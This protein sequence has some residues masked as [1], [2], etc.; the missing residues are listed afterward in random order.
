MTIKERQAKRQTLDFDVED[1]DKYYVT[2]PH[3]RHSL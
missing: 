2:K 1:E 3:T